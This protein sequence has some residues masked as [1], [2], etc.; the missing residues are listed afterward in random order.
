[1]LS[2]I[3]MARAI[4]MPQVPKE[5]PSHLAQERCLRQIIRHPYTR[6]YFPSFLKEND[7]SEENY[8]L[9]KGIDKFCH[10]KIKRLKKELDLKKKNPLA[11]S[12]RN[13]KDS[14]EAH[15]ACASDSFEAKSIELYYAIMMADSFRLEID[16]RLEKYLSR[17]SRAI[18]SKLNWNHKLVCM[19]EKLIHKCT[20]IKS[21]RQTYSC[22]ERTLSNGDE[23]EGFERECPLED[24]P[25]QLI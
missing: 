1:M 6:D 14:L 21:L 11:Y 19:Q 8:K 7:V 23:M 24:L 13:K 22:I 9:L 3:V 5:G 16:D 10:C 2:S 25:H 17:Y 12:F 15:D 20:K 4:D 18:A